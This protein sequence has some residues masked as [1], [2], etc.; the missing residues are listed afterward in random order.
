MRMPSSLKLVVATWI[1]AVVGAL[2]GRSLAE[3]GGVA[4]AAERAGAAVQ[5]AVR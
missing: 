4:A 1:A 2:A 5:A 3:G